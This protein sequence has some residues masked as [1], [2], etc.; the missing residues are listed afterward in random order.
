MAG[1]PDRP[2]RKSRGGI[3]A[4]RGWS[5][6][7]LRRRPD[8]L[9]LALQGGGAHGAFTWGVLARLLEAEIRIEGISGASAG[10][11]NAVA[12][13]AG[14]LRGGAAGASQ[15]LDEL[16]REIGRLAQLSPLRAGGLTQMAADFAAQYL[17]PYQLNPLGVNP[18]RAVLE[19]LVEFERLRVADT[20]RLFI[21]ATSVATGRARIFRNAELN[22]DAILASACLPQLHPAITIDGQPYWD[23]GFSANPP[24]VALVEASRARDL[25]LVQINPLLA[26]R[27]PRTPSE[28]RNRIAEIAFGRPLAEEL[29][30]LRHGVR[31]FGPIAWLSTRH[32]RLLRHRL[33]TI[34]GSAELSRLDP[35]TKVDPKWPLLLELR[36]RGWRAAE[37][38]LRGHGEPSTGPAATARITS[39]MQRR[40]G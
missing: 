31:S 7:L 25:L 11:L 13:A 23:G 34:D 29:E 27:T 38:W 22:V 24:L 9:N 21:A 10:A 33:H 3:A 15:A 8:R 35:R 37:T 16:W 28:I 18:L 2:Q 6:K 39:Q 20:P 5:A 17:S 26:E 4:G 36:E 30:R 32:R 1:N 40:A 14:W 12:L 19:R